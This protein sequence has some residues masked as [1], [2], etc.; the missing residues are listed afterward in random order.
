M[1]LLLSHASS[2]CSSASFVRK[3]RGTRVFDFTNSLNF[4]SVSASKE[5]FKLNLF[6]TLLGDSILARNFFLQKFFSQ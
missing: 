1:K 3:N 6:D 5:D 4:P 2:D